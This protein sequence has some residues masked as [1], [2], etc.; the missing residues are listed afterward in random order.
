MGLNYFGKSFGHTSPEP[1][2]G[3]Y[4]VVPMGST[5]RSEGT[6]SGNGTVGVLQ[7]VSEPR[8][9]ASVTIDFP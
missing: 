9:S 5:P 4:S 7:M 2:S 1:R 8:F 6:D 3:E